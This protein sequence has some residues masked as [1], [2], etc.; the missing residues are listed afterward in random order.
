[1][2]NHMDHVKDVS[3]R[4][5]KEFEGR[6]LILYV[7]PISGKQHIGYGRNI[8]DRGITIEEASL[9]LETDI[10][11]AFQGVFTVFDEF[12][13]NS[14][15]FKWQ[16]G[17]NPYMHQ[18][19]QRLPVLV[20]LVFNMGL[21]KFMEFKRMIKAIKAFDWNTAAEE[22]MNSRYAE[23]L[24]KRAEDNAFWL[25]HGYL[26]VNCPITMYVTSTTGI[27]PHQFDGGFSR[28]L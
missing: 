10:N 16:A 11:L 9:M 22:L 12:D 14:P 3:T 1:V 20:D 18:T 27:T 26:K 2:N 24:P 8:E 23:Q 25:K 19:F 7:D 21:P 4:R 28:G 15:L 17:P 5:T 6:K 13:P